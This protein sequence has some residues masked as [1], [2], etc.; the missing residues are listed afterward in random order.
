MPH[1]CNQ[2]SFPAQVTDRLCPVPGRSAQRSILSV[3]VYGPIRHR[4]AAA[5][6]PDLSPEAAV[7]LQSGVRDAVSD[8]DLD[9]AAHFAKFAFAAYGY[10][11]YVWSKP[12]WKCG[13][14]PTL[15]PWPA[16]SASCRRAAPA[17]TPP[18][19]LRA[20]PRP[21]SWLARRGR[22]GALGPGCGALRGPGERAPRPAARPAAGLFPPVLLRKT[23]PPAGYAGLWR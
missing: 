1:I 7:R 16:R 21:A 13:P 9:E 23:S 14:Y 15:A 22:A 19:P 18:P 3:I 11:L 8:A 12:Q 6:R 20:A 17:R 5:C 2:A 10:M 4:A